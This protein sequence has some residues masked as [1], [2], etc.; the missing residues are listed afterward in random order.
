MKRRG[1]LRG[2]AAAAASVMV[3]LQLAWEPLAPMVRIPLE[4]I[5]ASIKWMQLLYN[6]PIFYTKP[7]DGHPHFLKIDPTD[8]HADNAIGFRNVAPIDP[9]DMDLE[10]MRRMA[11]YDDD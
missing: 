6:T 2:L 5:D 7:G 8:V 1:F 9:D 11:E 4:S 3:P 10:D